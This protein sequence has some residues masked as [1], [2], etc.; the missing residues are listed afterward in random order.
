MV[1]FDVFTFPLRL[2]LQTELAGLPA[3]DVGLRDQ[4][5]A[6]VLEGVAVGD[7]GAVRALLVLPRV[8]DRH[9]LLVDAEV[10]VS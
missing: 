5:V 3:P 8:H 6:Q 7:V 4:D 2:V 1:R 10:K 9:H